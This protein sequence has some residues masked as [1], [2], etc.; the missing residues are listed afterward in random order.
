MVSFLASHALCRHNTNRDDFSENMFI[1]RHVTEVEIKTPAPYSR[2][3]LPESWE[4]VEIMRSFLPS[5]RCILFQ[6]ERQTF[7]DHLSTAAYPC[8]W[9][10]SLCTCVTPAHWFCSQNNAFSSLFSKTIGGE[11]PW[12]ERFKSTLHDNSL[13]F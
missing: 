3:R 9:Q 8:C 11:S 7:G 5:A 10:S 6:H 13:K 1:T 2:F 4:H 12:T